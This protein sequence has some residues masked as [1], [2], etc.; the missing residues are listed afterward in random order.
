MRPAA[1]LSSWYGAV[2]GG[3]YHEDFEGL[4]LQVTGFH[5]ATVFFRKFN[6]T[7]FVYLSKIQRVHLF[8]LFKP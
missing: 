3:E 1:L 7:T 6:L 2:L 8:E 5:F 4:L